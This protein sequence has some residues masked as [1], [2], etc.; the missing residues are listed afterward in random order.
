MCVPLEYAKTSV[1]VV[2]THHEDI[3]T[4]A[5]KSS[6]GGKGGGYFWTNIMRERI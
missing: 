1:V 3:A 5:A 2:Y 4:K 6:I